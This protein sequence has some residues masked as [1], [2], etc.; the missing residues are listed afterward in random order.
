MSDP[1]RK[2]QSLIDCV[3]EVN[4]GWYSLHSKCDFCFMICLLEQAVDTLE[5]EEE[6]GAKIPISLKLQTGLLASVSSLD[7]RS[8]SQPRGNSNP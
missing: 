2:V 3:D 6:L 5:K 4:G 7:R 8:W 1:R